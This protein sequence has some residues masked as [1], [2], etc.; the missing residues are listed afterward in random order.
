[1]SADI[2]GYSALMERDETG[3]LTRLKESRKSLFD[4]RVAAQGGRIFKVMG[5]GVLIEFP[6][7]ASAVTCAIEIQDAMEAAERH[8]PEDERLRY[9][10][11]IN[12]GDVIIDGDDIYGD[13]VNVAAR[14]Q[15]L[16]PEGGVALSR[17]VRDQASGPGSLP[18]AYPTHHLHN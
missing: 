3:T 10:V 2:V 18:P 13:G 14:L 15:A 16:A 11:G 7:A 9:R 12:L 1:M 6:S 4:P 17:N 8:R 5:D